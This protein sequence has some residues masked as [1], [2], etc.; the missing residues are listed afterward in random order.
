MS[1]FHKAGSTD[2]QPLAKAVAVTN[3][4]NVSFRREIG[5]EPVRGGLGHEVM[6][7]SGISRVASTYASFTEH[8]FIS[9]HGSRPYKLYQPRQ[10][11]RTL[12]PLVV[13]MHA[14]FQSAEDFA[15]GTRM[16]A[17]ADEFGF[18]VAYPVQSTSSNP[19]GAW[20]WFKP[21]HQRRGG[22][23]PAIIAGIASEIIATHAVDPE[24]VFIAGL[25]AGAAAVA[26]MIDTYPELFRA[27]G[28]HSGL[29]CG[30]AT[31]QSAAFIVMKQGPSVALSQQEVAGR[32]PIIVFHGD[33]DDTIHPWNTAWI[34]NAA[35]ERRYASVK[36]WIGRTPCGVKFTKTVYRN[37]ENTALIENFLVHGG[38]HAWFGGS[39]AGSYT[40]PSGP[41]ASREMVRFFM[42]HAQQWP[43]ADGVATR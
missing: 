37:H 42:Q 35:D 11:V 43:V 20:N 26:V 6:G 4:V 38:G 23:E 32:V 19:N 17:M 12:W 36:E 29:A 8:N 15:V 28:I 30:V 5:S 25:S 10:M 16:N 40:D 27:A 21:E 31:D 41:D 9:E 22:G 18:I 24:K 13:M 33:E 7:L 14:P 3:D 1:E 39:A 2:N 34:I